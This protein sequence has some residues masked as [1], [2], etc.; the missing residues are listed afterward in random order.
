[1]LNEHF[2][3]KVWQLIEE[4]KEANKELGIDLPKEFHNIYK[5]S[6]ELESIL[7]NLKDKENHN[8]IHFGKQVCKKKCSSCVTKI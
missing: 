4:L 7:L 2:I 5:T 6:E 1:M 3:Q 8:L